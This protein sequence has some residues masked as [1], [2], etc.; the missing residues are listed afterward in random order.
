[1][2]VV[3]S[4]TSPIRALGHLDHL[5]LLA[6]LFREVI[7]PPAVVV[8]LEQP[9]PRF[10]P[11]VVGSF[12]FIHVRS[13]QDR[14]AVDQLRQTLGPGEAEAIILAEELHAEAILID[15]AAGRAVA[16][17]RGLRPIGVLGTLLR[18]KRR[19][20]VP[21]V[22]PLLDRLQIENN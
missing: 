9:R 3:V 22:S 4:D 12:P 14:V 7:V 5:N 16:V 20:L 8:E 1:L 17:Q 6:S 10:A 2:T 18:A 15:E 19:G 11:V 21:A 13:P